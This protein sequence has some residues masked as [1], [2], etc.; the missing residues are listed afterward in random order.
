MLQLCSVELPEELSFC[1][2]KHDVKGLER[3]R[4]ESRLLLLEFVRPVWYY[5]WVEA[6]MACPSR[7]TQAVGCTALE[8]KFGVVS[9]SAVRALFQSSAQTG[10]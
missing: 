1:R 2:A 10:C 3:Q 6:W 4:F 5:R 8:M 7:H 9:V